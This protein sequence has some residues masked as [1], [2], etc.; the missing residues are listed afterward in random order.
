MTYNISKTLYLNI[1]LCSACNRFSTSYVEGTWIESHLDFS[2]NYCGFTSP[3]T[4]G[5]IFTYIVDNEN[6]VNFDTSAP[7]VTLYNPS[8][9]S[10]WEI[11]YNESA[12]FTCH[13]ILAFLQDPTIPT[14]VEAF[15]PSR[16]SWEGKTE[17]VFIDANSAVV[18]YTANIY[19]Q[20]QGT[21]RPYHCESV[22][23]SHWGKQQ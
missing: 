3:L 4:N 17:G 13:T 23:T 7:P 22:F 10:I 2:S 20:E 19:C 16:C 12:K 1:L 8:T 21:T 11:C 15:A 18:V 9:D 14:N 5:N 6:N